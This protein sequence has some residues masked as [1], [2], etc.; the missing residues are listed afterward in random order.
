MENDYQSLCGTQCWSGWTFNLIQ[1]ASFQVFL[2]I[3][4]LSALADFPIYFC[5]KVFIKSDCQDGQGLRR[6]G[7]VSDK[8]RHVI[9]LLSP[10]P[11]GR[12]LKTSPPSQSSSSASWSPWLNRPSQ[13]V[14]R[15]VCTNWEGVME[16]HK[17]MAGLQRRSS[18]CLL[19]M[20]FSQSAATRQQQMNGLTGALC[21]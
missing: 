5:I 14:C 10:G 21:L 18:G 2:F 6:C 15:S 20:S 16:F 9:P 19:M 1:Q 7:Y 3:G 12:G 13:S 11:W 8:C 4:F 17:G